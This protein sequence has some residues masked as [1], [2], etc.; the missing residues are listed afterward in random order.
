MYGWLPVGH[1]T[2]KRGAESDVCPCCGAPDE[3]LEHLF[4]CPN[5]QMKKCIRNG[6]RQAS[7]LCGDN[8]I[9]NKIS[10]AF[11]DIMIA[12]TTN[13]HPTPKPTMSQD[14]HRAFQAQ[15]QIGFHLFSRGFIAKEWTTAMK[16]TKTKYPQWKVETMLS[17]LWDCIFEPMWQCRN[18]ILHNQ[19]NH[20]ATAEDNELSK[21]LIWF[22]T[23]QNT[24]L[25]YHLRHFADISCGDI[26]QWSRPT[27]RARIKL[28]EAAQRRLIIQLKQ[29]AQK[30][31]V[32]PSYFRAIYDSA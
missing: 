5:E 1:N 2:A 30:Q 28:L 23:N 22:K 10:A 31:R 8:K 32:L 18:N 24:A 15:Q 20:R 13:Q 17:A 27:K 12:Y 11:F 7:R 25:A 21:K 14:T 19:A 26:K 9:P 4:I 3:T 29:T 16:S 6:I